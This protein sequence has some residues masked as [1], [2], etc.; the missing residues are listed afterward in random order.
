MV[1]FQ[2]WF[3]LHKE[4]RIVGDLG[5]IWQLTP[6][7]SLWYDDWGH[8]LIKHCAFVAVGD[9]VVFCMWW[10]LLEFISLGLIFSYYH[11]LTCRINSRNKTAQ[12]KCYRPVCNA[13]LEDAGPDVWCMLKSNEPDT[14]DYRDSYHLFIAARFLRLTESCDES[15]TGYYYSINARSPYDECAINLAPA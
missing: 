12:E 1:C 5:S 10:D 14:A 15:Q 8:R 7:R 13:F 2:R 11:L 9:S 4:L 3:L 6:W